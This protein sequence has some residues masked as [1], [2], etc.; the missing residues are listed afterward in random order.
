MSECRP[1]QKKIMFLNSKRLIHERTVI[2][3]SR[4]FYKCIR[5]FAEKLNPDYGFEKQ[6]DATDTSSTG[7]MPFICTTYAKC[8][9]L[10][11]SRNHR[12]IKHHANVLW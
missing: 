4:R 9:M 6:L 12:Q 7:I 8:L 10:Y 2:L 1:K 5:H 11:K 3:L